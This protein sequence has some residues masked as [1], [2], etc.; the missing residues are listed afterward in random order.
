MPSHAW[1]DQLLLLQVPLLLV[2]HLLVTLRP[3]QFWIGTCR[4]AP[5]SSQ[6]DPLHPLVTSVT[7]HA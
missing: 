7:S 2:M 4:G 6:I 5:C 3:L 1:V